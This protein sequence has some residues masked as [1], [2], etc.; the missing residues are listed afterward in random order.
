M[1]HIKCSSEFVQEDAHKNDKIE[2]KIATMLFLRLVK[3]NRR[4]VIHAHHHFHLLYEKIHSANNS[5]C[6]KP[7]FLNFNYSKLILHCTRPRGVTK[8]PN[9]ATNRFI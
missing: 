5:R 7:F 1:S 8:K 2:D 4:N 6:E 9:E 3:K